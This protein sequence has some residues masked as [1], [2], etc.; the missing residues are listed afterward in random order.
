MIT[1]LQFLDEGLSPYLAHVAPARGPAV[2]SWR[3][4]DGLTVRLVGMGS[5]TRQQGSSRRQPG[6]GP[7][8]TDRTHEIHHR[9]LRPGA[10]RRRMIDEVLGGVFGGEIGE[11]LRGAGTQR[12]P[13]R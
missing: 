10:A 8:R 3:Q 2:V 12:C 1:S 9:L 7:H 11:R 4:P 13:P 6:A 5:T